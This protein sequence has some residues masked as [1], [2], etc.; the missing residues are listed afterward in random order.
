M[1]S[2]K[3]SLITINQ[4][5]KILAKLAF[6]SLLFTFSTIDSL[7]QE[8]SFTHVDPPHWYVGFPSDTLEIL[9]H[10]PKIGLN[11][12][13]IRSA[14][15]GVQ[16]LPTKK[17]PSPNYTLLR[18]NIPQGTQPHTFIIESKGKAGKF[19]H[20][21]TLKKRSSRKRG[22]DTEDLIYLITPDRFANGNPKNDAFTDMHQPGVN[23]AE[24][25]Q[26]HGGDIQGMIDHLD[27]IQELGMTALWPNPLLENNQDF[28]S[29]HGYAFT[30]YYKI[31]KRFGSNELFK[32]LVDSLHQRGMKMIM[33]VV[34]N[35]IGNRHYLYTDIPD[36]NWFHFWPEYTQT[37]YRATTLMDPYTSQYDLEKMQNGWFDKHM[38]DL[39]QQNAV[40]AKYLIQQTLWWIEAFDLDALRI[41]TYAYPDQYFMQNWGKALKMAYPDIFLFAETWVHGPTVQGYFM[42]DALGSKTNYLDALTDFQVHYAIN[43]ALTRAQSWTDGVSRLYYTLAADYIYEKP[44][45]MVTFVDNHDLARFHGVVGKDIRKFEIGMGLLYTLR[46][47]PSVYY[48][49]EILMA[50]TDGHGKIRQDFPGGWP[51]DLTNKFLAQGRTDEENRAFDYLKS[52]AE[53]RKAHPA[54]TKGGL[55]QFV[56][57]KDIYVYERTSAA[58]RVVVIVNVSNEERIVNNARFLESVPTG[59]TLVGPSGEERIFG[60]KWTLPPF[61]IY[62][63]ALK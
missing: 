17:L 58:D 37:N 61:S 14:E 49:T 3:I 45:H 8:K 25:Y 32:S 53:F 36:S 33:D 2:T 40:L 55:K 30:D 10:H 54:L 50:E 11:E 35:H 59:A 1:I 56:P 7:A 39:N 5:I 20:N 34:Y 23:R 13:T 51:G 15:T 28:E 24:P 63:G 48:G 57:E 19:K 26:R 43:D 18:L 52:L 62:I 27:F 41:D 6:A 21:Y 12:T 16:L 44:E 46:G 47:I 4:L 22:L 60:E 31:D 9:L 38:P 42:G 29:Y